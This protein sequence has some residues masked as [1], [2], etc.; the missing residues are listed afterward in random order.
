MRFFVPAISVALLTA[1]LPGAASAQDAPVMPALS[2]EVILPEP[3]TLDSLFAD[4]KRS[5]EETAA[6]AIASRIDS[7]LDTSPSA[8]VSLLFEWADKADDEGRSAS[9]LDFLSEAISLQP[10]NAAAYRKRA[11]LHYTAGDYVKTM[12]DIRTALKLEPRDFGSLGLMA[13][14]L[15]KTGHEEES[16]V[17]WRQYLSIYPADRKVIGHIDEVDQARAGRRL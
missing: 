10:D 17:V 11:V 16:V 6:S 9:A 2:E 8:T 1:T 14:I 4:L 15:D 3:G 13:T 12:D 7:L 5:R